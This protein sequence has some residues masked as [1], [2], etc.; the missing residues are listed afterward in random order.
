[1]FR[2]VFT[3][4]NDQAPLQAAE[5]KAGRVFSHR[6]SLNAYENRS[7]GSTSGL[8]TLSIVII[9]IDP[10]SN[11]LVIYNNQSGP[12]GQNGWT[13]IGALFRYEPFN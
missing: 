6:L 10:G 4:C 1:M 7:I 8:Q 11:P 9:I 2:A 3:S 12:F 13:H 5:N